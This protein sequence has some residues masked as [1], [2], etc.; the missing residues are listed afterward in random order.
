MQATFWQKLLLSIIAGFFAACLVQFYKNFIQ[1]ADDAINKGYQ[2]R[3]GIST[4]R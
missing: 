4:S 1:G 3:A 2:N